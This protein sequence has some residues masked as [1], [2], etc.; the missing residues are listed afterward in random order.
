Q[1]SVA[2]RDRGDLELPHLPGAPHVAARLGHHAPYA[3]LSAVFLGH[4]SGGVDE[5][6]EHELGFAEGPGTRLGPA[7]NDGDRRPLQRAGEAQFVVTERGQRLL[8][9]A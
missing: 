8:R 3:V 9:A 2:M 1:L 6:F 5:T 7:W 4:H